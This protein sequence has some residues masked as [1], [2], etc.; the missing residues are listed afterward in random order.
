MSSR[1][2]SAIAT[3]A[4][5]VA[6][7]MSAGP[8][9]GAIGPS[10]TAAPSVEPESSPSLPPTASPR[11]VRSREPLPS[12][13]P[14]PPLAPDAARPVLSREMV[15]YLPYWEAPGYDP[16]TD[17]YL[18]DRR[19]TDLVLFSVGVRRDGSLRLDTPGARF[20]L[21]DAATRI[22][23]AAHAQGIRVLVSFTSFSAEGNRILFG[24]RTAQDRFVADAAALVRLRGLDG[25]DLDVEHI[26][27]VRFGGYARTAGRLRDALVADNPLARVTVATNGNLSGA[28]M[29]AAAISEGA[30]RAFL[31]GYAY[32][33]PTSDPVGSIS[34]ISSVGRL[35]LRESLGIYRDNG[36]PLHQVIVGLPAYGMTWATSGPG[37][38]AGRAPASVSE[39]GS[40]IPFRS[41]LPDPLPPGAILDS[42]ADEGSAR[43]AWF[44]PERGSWFQ[45]Y[46]DTPATLRAKYLLAHELGLAGVGMWTLGYDGGLAGYPE[47]VRDT[48]ELPVVAS[49]DVGDPVTAD[50]AVNVRV[51]LYDGPAPVDAVRLS[52]DGT[53]WSAWRP[54]HASD[55]SLS[56]ELA[57]GLDGSRVVV[58]QSRDQ[59]GAISAPV[60]ASTVLDRRP[61]VFSGIGL[62]ELVPGAWVVTFGL[63]DL[64]GVDRV[65]I[66]WRTGAAEWGSWRPLDSLAAASTRAPAGAPVSVAV[67]AW[68][69]LGHVA[70][71]QAVHDPSAALDEHAGDD[72]RCTTSTASSM[73]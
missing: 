50:R 10:P 21:G 68:D 25:A 17:P 29:A 59:G 6:G 9:P 31:M 48:F 46:Y 22:I 61:P 27:K 7:C 49:V 73:C 20:V 35:D 40:S 72:A 45:T 60:T 41:A 1:A 56:W 51:R 69:Q 53:T 13:E 4:L 66:R 70:M 12:L 18:R 58:V 44:D 33:G 14:L 19:L 37:L 65:E 30:D 55:H 5:L 15:A 11:P 26:K 24:D 32:R 43:V 16:G 67:R 52:N 36:V 64:T 8:A 42:D 39:R 62:R 2:A 28:R 23:E 54:T 38:R 3:I 34:P 63:S 71:R 57:P 47:L